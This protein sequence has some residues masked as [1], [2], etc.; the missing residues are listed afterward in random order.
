MV[1]GSQL[2][3]LDPRGSGD[4]MRGEVEVVL[5]LVEV[6]GISQVETT[7]AWDEAEDDPIGAWLD[8]GRGAKVRGKNVFFTVDSLKAID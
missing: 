2:G 4:G 8:G 5:D 1:R 3:F 6:L 7:I